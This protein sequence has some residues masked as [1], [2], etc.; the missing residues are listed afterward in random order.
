[1]SKKLSEIIKELEDKGAIE[2][3]YFYREYLSKK[4]Q[5]HLE[6]NQDLV[7]QVLQKTKE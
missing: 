7:H 1:M 3:Y 4:T 2:K 5:L 6:L